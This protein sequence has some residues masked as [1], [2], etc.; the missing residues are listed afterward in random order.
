M[1]EEERRVSAG[2]SLCRSSNIKDRR[3]R[4]ARRRLSRTSSDE[5]PR[6]SRTVAEDVERDS[7]KNER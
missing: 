1:K 7:A 2:G 4:R 5:T 3:G 6:G